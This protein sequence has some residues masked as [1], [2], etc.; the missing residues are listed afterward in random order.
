MWMWTAF[1]PF[2]SYFLKKIHFPCK[3]VEYEPHNFTQCSSLVSTVAHM[4]FSYPCLCSPWPLF[5]FLEYLG[6]LGGFPHTL[7]ST[8]AGESCSYKMT[9][10]LPYCIW[11]VKQGKVLMPLTDHGGIT[12][13]CAQLERRWKYYLEFDVTNVFQVLIEMGVK[14]Y[15]LLKNNV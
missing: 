3:G 2:S 12:S 13:F 5:V 8:E 15:V 7:Y 10:L 9:L 6:T 4:L 14:C 11:A 1:L